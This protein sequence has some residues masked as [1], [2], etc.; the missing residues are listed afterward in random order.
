MTLFAAVREPDFSMYTD[1]TNGYFSISAIVPMDYIKFCAAIDKEKQ[2]LKSFD[3]RG[4]G[5]RWETR[6]PGLMVPNHPR[7]QLR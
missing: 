5:P 7:Y 2:P 4:C 6:T 1:I 3:F